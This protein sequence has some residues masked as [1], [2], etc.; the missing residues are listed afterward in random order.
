MAEIERDAYALVGHAF[1]IGSPKQ[2][3]EILFG[4]LGVA[5]G[6]KAKTGALTTG[7]DVLE[8]IAAQDPGSAGQLAQKVLDWRQIAKLKSTYSDA[9][10]DEINP[11]TD[12][13]HTTFAM[14]VASTGRLSSTSPNLQDRKSVVEGK[15]V[16]VRLDLGGRLDIQKKKQKN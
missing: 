3:S 10:V 12:R 11:E 13:V 15:S 2:I 6:R 8:E 4:E 16:S 9:L 7:A 14:T 5:G 1:N